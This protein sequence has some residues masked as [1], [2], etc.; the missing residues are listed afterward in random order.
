QLI[1]HYTLKNR[2]DRP[3]VVTLVLAVRPLQVNPPTQ[4]LNVQGGVAP[5][6]DLSWDGR[7]LSVDGRRRLFP[8]Q[9][10]DEVIAAGFD[11]GN[12]PELLAMPRPA[13]ATSVKDEAGFASGL[14]LY[15]L[16]L[17]PRGN[18][19]IAIVVPLAGEPV[20]PVQDTP[21]W[22]DREQE[23][24]AAAW[25]E[26]LNRVAL[27]LPPAGRPLADTLR[28]AL[29]HILISRSEAA[30]RPGT[31]AYARSW[32]RDGAMMSSALLRLG[33]AGVSR[34]YV[35]WFAAHQFAS[36]KVPCC[37]D[38]RGSDP[39][40]ENDSPGELLHLIAEQYRYTRDRA[41]LRSMWPRVA[42]AAAY[43][44]SLRLKERTAQNLT[45]ERRAF[46]GLMPPSI[47]H[48]GYSDRPAYSYWDDFWALAGYDGAVATAQ[49]LGRGNDAR[50]LVRQRQE[51]DRDLQASLRAS[52]ARH[53]IDYL[54]ASAD[55]GD[56][57]PTSTTIAL[58]VA[59]QQAYLPQ[60]ELRQT[61]ERYWKEFLLRRDGGIKWE[62]YTPYELR[63]VGTYVRLGSR[64]RARELLDFFL[65]DRRPA[66]WNQWA[67]VVGRELREPRFVGD[68]PHAWI[69][70][71][72][73]SSVL[74]L[75]AYER[76]A[77]RALVLAAG[78][79]TDWLAGEGIA[80]ERLRTHYGELSYTLRHDR[81]RL[82]LK[83]AGGLRP[84]PGGLVLAWPYAGSPPPA[85]VNGRPARWE[86]DTELRI[87]TL[88]AVIAVGGGPGGE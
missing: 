19:R 60:R 68:M 82:V 23:K 32:I 12:V 27:R 8:L 5:I 83:I 38:Y 87:R 7:A 35:E 57:D 62:A 25:R 50:R 48:E 43:M 39:V 16:A 20:L 53:D 59:G 61:F 41:W 79:P 42:A 17:P 9:K 72:F 49:A 2:S 78:V 14:L 6:R 63:S 81:G 3:R 45:A 74:D 13:P 85:F 40:A 1:A 54:P 31:R 71:D 64:E 52:I 15:R 30:L 67:E 86:N 77:D 34:A 47:S 70:S 24:A 88:P 4:F 44:D 65:K 18:R 66:S 76:A 56:F 69:A 37:V 26:K 28:T 84:P 21:A 33:H 55:R 46:H 73:I 51:F 80:I 58:S 75:F 22:L 36:G 10:P 11:A 29:A